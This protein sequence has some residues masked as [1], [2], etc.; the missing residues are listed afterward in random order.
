MH[1]ELMQDYWDAGW[2]HMPLYENDSV[3]PHDFAP[4][5]WHAG[6]PEPTLAQYVTEYTLPELDRRNIAD[7]YKPMDCAA[8]VL[9]K[10]I[11]DAIDAYEGGAR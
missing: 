2:V 9:P 11:A 1:D 4:L 7:R 3:M 5:L 10:I 6:A 8:D